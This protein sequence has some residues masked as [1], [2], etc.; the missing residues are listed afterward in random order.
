MGFPARAAVLLINLGTPDS[1]MVP[2]VRRFLGEML[3]D[4]YLVD[5]PKFLWRPILNG[6]ILNVRPGN[7]ARKY[8]AIWTS[9][10]SPLKAHMARTAALLG[11]SLKSA[12]RSGT[13]P[14]VDFAMRYGQPSIPAVL[15]RLK[16]AGHS[17]ILL[18]PLYPHYSPA[19][20]ATALDAAFSWA[21][22]TS[23]PPELRAVESYGDHPGYI[24]ALAAGIRRLWT[25]KGAPGDCVLM[26]FHGLPRA[27]AGS[28]AYRDACLR[29]AKHLAETLELYAPD[30]RIGFQSRFGYGKWIEPCTETTLAALGKKGLKRLDV[31][32]PGFSADCL[33]TLWEIAVEGK[34]VFQK[35]GGGEFNFVPCLNGNDVWIRALTEISIDRLRNG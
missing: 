11:E 8:A 1:A 33:E 9:E 34:A 31:V 17:T 6:I 30:W 22:R 3:S 25:E 4:P 19:T 29:T 7:S 24:A 21:R 14:I 27:A 16:N 10:G 2:D 20:T 15:E 23:H 12:N 26:S 18:F 35:S 13:P 28:D 32:C 5:L